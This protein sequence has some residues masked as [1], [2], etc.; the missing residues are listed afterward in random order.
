MSPAPQP[1]LLWLWDARQ[2]P[3]SWN[4]PSGDRLQAHQGVMSLLCTLGVRFFHAL[5]ARLWFPVPRVDGLRAVLCLRTSALQDAAC[6][7]CTLDGERSVMQSSSPSLSPSLCPSAPP[8]AHSTGTNHLQNQDLHESGCI[9]A[10]PYFKDSAEL[11]LFTAK[12]SSQLCKRQRWYWVHQSISR[13]G[14]KPGHVS[15]WCS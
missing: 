14:T 6:V 8:E 15:V 2:H 7:H 11:P 12:K 3:H 1:V 4:V 10:F 5:R 13:A 9:S